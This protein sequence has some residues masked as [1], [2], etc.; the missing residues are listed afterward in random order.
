VSGPELLLNKNTKDEGNSKSLAAF[1][2]LKP[3]P[4]RS[5]QP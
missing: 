1:R 5:R 4:E 3:L 2:L